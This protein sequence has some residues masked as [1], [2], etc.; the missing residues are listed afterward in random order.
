MP[1]DPPR[2]LPIDAPDDF[3]LIGERT[4][5]PSNNVL[6]PIYVTL[7]ES[8]TPASSSAKIDVDGIAYEDRRSISRNPDV[9][10]RSFSR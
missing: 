5:R 8:L 9:D 1:N 4:K 2:R 3:P 6:L 7:L 10:I